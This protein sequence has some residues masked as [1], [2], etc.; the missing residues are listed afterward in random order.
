MKKVLTFI[1]GII[2]P[3][4]LMAGGLV[5]NTNHS[6]AWVRLPARNAS[7]EIDAV[8]YNPAGLMKLQNGFHISL[9]NQTIFQT[10]EVENFYK[11]PGGAFGLNEPLFTGKVKAPLFPAIYAAYKTERLA[12][13][14][15]FNPI[16]GGGGAEYT[17][18]LPSFEMGPADLVP[19][20]AA[21]QGVSDYRLDAY[22]KGSS[23]YFGL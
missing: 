16:G 10:R 1:A 17:K 12:F 3:G 15:G 21:S 18:G 14:I 6:A 5:T 23:V 2:V 7:T 20:L 9:S 13:S 8:Y 22:L 4:I 19:A 11:G